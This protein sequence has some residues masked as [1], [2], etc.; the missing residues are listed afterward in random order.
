MSSDIT[1]SEAVISESSNSSLG[2]DI[3]YFV[4]EEQAKP[5]NN[6]EN[7]ILLSD[8]KVLNVPE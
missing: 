5:S 4:G 2:P 8:M 6:L 3:Q 7:E 1:V